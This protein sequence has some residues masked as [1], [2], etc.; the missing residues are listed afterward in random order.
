MLMYQFGTIVLFGLA[1]SAVVGL[2]QHLA[3]A[4]RSGQAVAALNLL[5]GL[6]LGVLLTWA[7]DYSMFAAWGI[8]F[9]EL[10][11]GPV[12]TGFVIGGVAAFWRELSTLV[13]SLARRQLD[14]EVQADAEARVARVA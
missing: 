3:P 9:R 1:V 11:M 10:W 5:L 14:E 13:A 12:A 7:L 8:Q 2:V 4:G 6:V